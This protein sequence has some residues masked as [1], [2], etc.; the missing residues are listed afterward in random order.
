MIDD[1][2]DKIVLVTGSS[3]GIGRAIALAFGAQ[4]SR[5]AVHYHSHDVEAE[6]VAARIRDMGGDS[7]AFGADVSN[8]KDVTRLI[9]DVLGAFGT[10]DVVVNNAGGFVRRSSLADAPDE[11]VDAIFDL[12]ARSMLAVNR[13]VIPE[14]R[15]QGRGSIINLTS[16]AA[17]TGATAGAGLYASTKAYISTYTR[18]LAKEVA[19]QGIRVNAIA[20]GVIDTPIHHGQTSE[21]LL[22]Q[23][24]AAIPM[25]RFG[26]AEECAGAA[27]FLASEELS[28]YITGQILEVNGAALMP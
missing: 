6:A 1:L 23:L 2:R 20:P 17:R 12:N 9:A 18:A 19:L 15:A 13:L 21:E 3:S 8:V 22:G 28:S 27:L 25:G 10:I 11:L 4:K 16:Q 7:S 14:M 5:V 24:L 26:R